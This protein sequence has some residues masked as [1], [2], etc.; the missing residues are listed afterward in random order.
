MNTVSNQ[1]N[2]KSQ[3]SYT[4]KINQNRPAPPLLKNLVMAFLIGGIICVIGQAILNLYIY[5]GFSPTEAANP[6]VATVIFLAALATGLGV[7]KKLGRFA[8]AGSFIPVTGFANAVTSAA[9]EFKKEGLIQGIG[10]KMFILAG[11][12]IVY[13]VVTAFVIG[14]ISVII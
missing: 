8:G 13:G 9:M 5:L 14:I 10:S 12:V 6:T 2:Y 1:E 11:S 7:Y 3:Y 4:Q